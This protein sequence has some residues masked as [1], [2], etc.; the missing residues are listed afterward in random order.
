MPHYSNLNVNALREKIYSKYLSLPDP[1]LCYSSLFHRV[2][3]QYK[4]V[5]FDFI[6]GI[7]DCMGLAI[8]CSRNNFQELV[9][10]MVCE[11]P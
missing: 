8:S 11:L 1:T 3:I 9:N 4:Y 10:S 2:G 7:L 6:F 5:Y